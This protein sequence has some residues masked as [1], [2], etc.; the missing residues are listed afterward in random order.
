MGQ[1]LTTPLSLTLDHWKEVR[2]RAQN[3]SVEVRK[4]NWT[5]FCTSDWPA[6]NVG[7]PWDGTFDSSVI[8]QVKSQVCKEG[9]EGHPDQVPYIF[10]WE[11]LAQNPPKWVKPFLFTGRI[12]TESSPKPAQPS[13]STPLLPTPA[14]Q[15]KPPLASPT[16]NL[17]PLEELDS[18]KPKKT[19]VLLGGQE[20]LL[21]FDTPPPYAPLPREPPAPSPDSTQREREEDPP[22]RSTPMSARLPLR[23]GAGSEDGQWEAQ[24]FPASLSGGQMHYWPFSASDLYNWRTHNPPFSQDPQALTGLIES[25]LLTHQPTWEDC[26]QLLQALLTTEERQRVLMEARKNVPGDNGQPTQLPNEIDAA[27]P[28]T[29]PDWDFSTAAGRERLRLYRQILLTGLRGAGRRPTNLAKGATGGKMY[30]WTTERQV[31]LATGRVTHSFLLVPDC[32]YPLLGRDLLS[33]VGAQIHFQ[34]EGA[35]VADPRG[36]LL[37]VLTLQL[38][39]EHRLYDKK[40]IEAPLAPEWIEKFPGS[41]AETGGI[42]L[43]VQQPPIMVNVKSTAEPISVQQYPMTKEAKDGIRPHI[44]RLLDLGILKPCQSPWNTPLLPVWK[45]GTNDFRPVQDLREVNRRV[46]DI[47]PTV[48][49]PYNL[50][51]TLPPSRTWYTV[52]DLKDAFFCL[53]LSPQSQPLFAFEWKDP[54]TGFSGQLTWTRLPQGFKNSPTLFDEALHHDLASFRVSNPQWTLLQYVDDLLLAAETEADCKR[55]TESLLQRLGELGYRASAKKAQLCAQQVVYLGYKLEGGRRWLT[56]GRKQAVALIPPPKNPRQLREF[57]GSAGFCRLWIPGFAEI[58]ASLYPL[59]R[60]NSPYVWGEEQQLAFDKLKKALLEAPALSLPDP[61]KP[62]TLYI[63]EKGGI[64]K[65][66]LTQKLGPWKRPVAYFSKKLDSVA[67][68]WPPCLRM[69]AAVAT[70]VKDS[71][72]LTMGQPLTIVTS[73]AIETIIRQPPD[74]WLSNARITHYQAMLLNPERIRFGTTASLNPATLLPEPGNQTQVSHNCQQVLA[75]VHGTREDL[76]DQPLPDAEHTWYTDGSSFLHQGERRAGAAVV[77]GKAVVWASALPPGTSAQKAELVALTQALRQAKGKRVNIYTDSRYA[78]A[79]AHVHGEIYKRRGLLT[80]GGREIKNK[81]EILDLLQALFLPKK[82]SIMHCPGHQRGEDP[83]AQGNRMADEVARTSAL[84]S[85][86]LTIDTQDSPSQGQEWTYTEQDVAAIQKL[87]GTYDEATK[88]WKIQD[89]IVLPRKETRRLVQDLHRWTHLGYKKLKALL[90]REETSHFLLELDTAVKQTVEACIPCAKVNPR[91]SKIPEGVRI[92]GDRPGVNWEVDFTEVRP[93]KYG[94]KYLLVFVDTFSGWPEAFPVK[95]ETAQVVV[96]KLLEEIFPRFGLPKVLGS[97][98]GPAFVSRVSQLVAK[99][100]GIDWKLHCAYRPQSSG[101][102]KRM[103]RTIKETLT[104]LIME[105]G[106]RDWVALLPMALFRARNTPS[107]YGLTPYEILYGGPPPA[108]D[109][110]GPSV[111][112]FATSPALQTRFR[113]LQ[114]IHEHVGKQLAAAY[115]SKCPVLPHSFQIGDAVYV[116]RH[117]TR[118]LEPRW[119]GPYMVLLTTPTAVKVDGIAAWIHVSHVKKA[120]AER[121]QETDTP[122]SEPAPEWKLQRTQ[123]PLKITLL[124][125]A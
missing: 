95:K 101:Q 45:P 69:I 51:S 60:T 125:S 66:V 82:V 9:K 56:E 108:V 24:A 19:P 80:S 32:P 68:G 102:V 94:M 70:A 81:Q 105:T 100:L 84:G 96:K 1:G 64:A 67:S 92:R 59:T 37:Q 74:R 65:G 77:D 35:S 116:R 107:V 39:D 87:G 28:L 76:T 7:W 31:D 5:V 48:P 62:F 16:S 120:V 6:F 46:E 44:K 97:D 121:N 22:V 14:D 79:T 38:E 110:L 26:Q 36:R 72:K 30:R 118:T 88:N 41:W 40:E 20:G 73:H 71:D 18:S 15:E 29:R 63:D 91:C 13:S 113:A 33:K 27:F 61:N 117:Q 119:K 115:Q 98:N 11:D 58:A 123:N 103:N 86:V 17:Y 112:S 75:E 90:D 83:V 12:R 89:K 122:T 8:L 93:S 23:G 106:T 2:E 85:S 111:D 99:V 25:I 55:G 104:K 57:L 78:F 10:V 53:R 52:L 43:A 47:H 49:N 124:K 42:G 21:L 34:K 109:L 114:L 54:E 50:L 3:L 4:K